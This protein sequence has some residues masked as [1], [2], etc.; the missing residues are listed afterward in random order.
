M[1]QGHDDRH[2]ARPAEDLRLKAAYALLEQANEGL[3][4]QL[5]L[6]PLLAR[7]RILA[8]VAGHAVPVIKLLPPF[9][10]SEEDLLWIESAFEQVV[11]E[12]ESLGGIWDLGRTLAGRA[13]RERVG[14]A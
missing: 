14:A 8:Q 1:R 5:I 10:V 6:V 13:L 3:F 9:V 11:R 4:C 7:H 12:A 2:P